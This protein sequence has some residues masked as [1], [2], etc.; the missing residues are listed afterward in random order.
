M[1]RKRKAPSDEVTVTLI[2]AHRHAGHYYAPG[3]SITVRR[4]LLPTLE[5]MGVIAP[6]A[7]T[8]TDATT[9]G[10]GATN[11]PAGDTDGPAAAPSDDAAPSEEADTD[12]DEP[13]RND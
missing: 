6:G 10:E 7:G 2:A 9:A 13:D 11:A 8:T 12:G 4:S 5:A 1:P 3:E